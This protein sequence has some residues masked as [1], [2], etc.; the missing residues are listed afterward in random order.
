M[1][2]ETNK[3]LMIHVGLACVWLLLMGIISDYFI[4]MILL[5][6]GYLIGQYIKLEE[7]KEK[8]NKKRK[9]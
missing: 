1:S 5:H 6:K 2:K 8:W 3:L 4:L 9:K 7:E